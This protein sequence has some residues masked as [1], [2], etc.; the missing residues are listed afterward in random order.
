MNID[1][2][3]IIDQVVGIPLCF[4]FTVFHKVRV[5]FTPERP[6]VVPKRI[7][8]LKPAE[9]GT[10]IILYPTIAKTKE[11]H[12][13]AEL[14]FVAFQENIAIFDILKVIPSANIFV[15]RTQSF[16]TVMSDTL[17]IIWKIRQ[18]KVDIVIDL[19]FFS[20][21]TALISYLT[22]APRRVGFHRF[23]SE[24]LYRGD[25]MTHSVAYNYYHHVGQSFMSLLLALAYP[26]GR[27]AL[28]EVLPREN[29]KI[30]KITATEIE[31][32]EIL[33]KLRQ[34]NS[35]ITDK[36][37]LVIF[38]PNTG[39]WLPYRKWPIDYYVE[40]AKKILAENESAYVIVTGTR[41][42]IQDGEKLVQGVASPKLIN[43]VCKT[44]LPEFI[45]LLNMGKV[46]V[47]VDSG[48]AHFAAL[49]DIGI[50]CIFGPDTQVVFAPL[51]PNAICHE[52]SLACHPCYSAFNNRRPN[53]DVMDKPC[54]RSISV[55][56]VYQSVKTFL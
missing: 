51:S 10:S 39:E 8:F 44:S 24:G 2:M 47:S 1:R 23:H 27:I 48:P 13:Q 40:L 38:S 37:K 26:P 46:I 42:A 55:E 19:E 7:L 34:F 11:L 5:F 45:H 32:V 17:R 21:Y 33:T 36:S 25:M 35:N 22:G 53:C 31:F 3:R 18:L 41:S 20:R 49:T 6:V 56:R 30:P 4:I 9:M 50:V 54:L 29:L 14:Y 43:L 28:Q 12:P 52:S 16:W 15:I